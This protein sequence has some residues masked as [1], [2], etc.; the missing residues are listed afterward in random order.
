MLTDLAQKRKAAR[1]HLEQLRAGR[2]RLLTAY[3]VVRR[4]LAEAT[5]E[6]EG[7]LIEAKRA[8][9]AAAR[10]VEEH[11]G[12]SAETLEAELAAGRL[13]GMPLLDGI[14]T[15]AEADT[16]DTRQPARQRLTS[17]PPWRKPR[18]R[19]PSRRNPST[20]R[21]DAIGVGCSGIA[22]RSPTSCPR[23]IWSR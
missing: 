11:E 18:S 22:A 4:T 16:P 23:P 19:P 13:V 1:V 12:E 10:R 8:A 20:F 15:A 7:V 3:D 6:L 9:G 17:S 2:D 5:G 14:E 21:L